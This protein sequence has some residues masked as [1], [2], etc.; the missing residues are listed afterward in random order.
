[1]GMPLISVN[2]SIITTLYAIESLEN[3]VN[4]P[5]NRYVDT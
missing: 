4:T 3:G 1:M 5:V 2:L